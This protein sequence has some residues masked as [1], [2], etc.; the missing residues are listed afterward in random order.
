MQQALQE[1]PDVTQPYPK[2][3][4][5]S[6]L[7]VIYLVLLPA[8]PCVVMNPFK[9]LVIHNQGSSPFLHVLPH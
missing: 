8:C 6:V 2:C 1:R 9:A 5:V 4:L 3:R 7:A